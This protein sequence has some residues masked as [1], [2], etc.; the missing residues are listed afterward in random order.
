MRRCRQWVITAATCDRLFVLQPRAAI[1]DDG[2]QHCFTPADFILHQNS[3]TNM[4]ITTIII[5]V[6]LAIVAIYVIGIYNR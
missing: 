4:G 6:I 5:L 2:N 3:G 1:S